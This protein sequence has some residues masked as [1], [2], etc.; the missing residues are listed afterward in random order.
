MLQFFKICMK[1]GLFVVFEGID[2]AGTSTQLPLLTA[3]IKKLSKYDEVLESHEPW[4]SIDAEKAIKIL[5]EDEDPF[6]KK[7][8]LAKLFVDD[9]VAHSEI[10]DKIVRWGAFVLLDRYSISTC[11]YQGAQGIDRQELINLHRG[12]G[13]LIPDITF[14][15]DVSQEVAEQRLIKRGAPKE[16]F[17]SNREFTKSLIKHYRE[18][19]KSDKGLFGKIKTIDGNPPIEKVAEDIRVTFNPIYEAWQKGERYLNSL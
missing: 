2:G 18:L 7:Y 16:K 3:H 17:E 1:K 4:N 15:I 9:R 14:F 13:I 10:L 6:S 5:E 11:A 12:K 8:E 19:A